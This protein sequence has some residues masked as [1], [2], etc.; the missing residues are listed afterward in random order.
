MSLIPH[1][2]LQPHPPPPHDFPLL[3]LVPIFSLFHMWPLSHPCLH[4]CWVLWSF[5]EYE[6]DP[7]REILASKKKKK[8]VPWS[9]KWSKLWRGKPTLRELQ[10]LSVIRPS[11]GSWLIN[12]AQPSNFQTFKTPEPFF[13]PVTIFAIPLDQCSKEPTLGNTDEH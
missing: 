11:K 13:L 5:R 8:R 7:G 4:A 12:F 1:P 3:L 10:W 6:M 9:N 2:H